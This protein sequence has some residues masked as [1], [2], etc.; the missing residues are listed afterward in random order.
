MWFSLLA[1][2]RS[3]NLKRRQSLGSAVVFFV[4]FFGVVGWCFCRGFCENLVAD[5]G[6]LMVNLWWDAGE[7]W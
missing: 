3:W 7:R 4:I 6:F 2:D 5:D 1:T